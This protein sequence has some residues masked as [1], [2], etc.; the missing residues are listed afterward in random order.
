ML[1]TPPALFGASMEDQKT[2]SGYAQAKNQA[3]GVKGI[4]WSS[5]QSIMARMYYLAALKAAKIKH[6]A[7]DGGAETYSAGCFWRENGLRDAP[8]LAAR[9]RCA[10]WRE[11]C[12]ARRAFGWLDQFG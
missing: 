10:V 9:L 1:G 5:V 7:F 2:A 6:A 3:M 4:P 12:G 8:G 11:R